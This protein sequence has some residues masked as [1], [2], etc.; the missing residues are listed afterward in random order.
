VRTETIL[1]PAEIE[2]IRRGQEDPSVISDYFF[3]P[4]GEEHG[5]LFDENFTEKGAWQKIVHKA[6]QRDIT[7]IGGFG[8]GKT[9]GIGMSAAVWGL[10]IRDFKFLNAAPKAWQ[11]KLMYDTILLNARNTRFEDFIWEKPRKPYPK[12]V[13]RFKMEDEIYESTLEFMSADKDATGILSWEG[14]WLHIDEAGLLD[15]LEEVI[16]NAGTRLRGSVRRRDRLGRFSMASNSWDNF[17]LWYYFD[18]AVADPDNFLSITVSSR[19]NKN[20]T[21]KQLERM[22]ARIPVRE[23]ER[24][25]EGARPEGKGRYFSRDHIYECEDVY[26]GQ[27][28]SSL[29]GQ[30]KPGYLYEKLHGAG[31]V[32]FRLPSQKDHLY[33]LFG[34]PGTG[35]APQRNAP[36]LMVWDVN[37]FPMLPAKLVAFWWGSGNG[38]IGPWVDM[39]FTLIDIYAPVYCG[40]DSTGP[41]KNMNYLINEHLFRERYGKKIKLEETSTEEENNDVGYL[42][43]LGKIKGIGALDFSGAMKSVY[44]Q[45]ARLLIENKLLA[46]PRDI[47]GIRSQLSNYDPENDKKIAQDI[48]AT[49]GMTAHG[50]RTWFHLSPQELLAT[51]SAVDKQPHSSVRRL[52]EKARNRRKHKPN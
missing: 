2:I 8:S 16:I 24:F 52:P 25:I 19:S 20:I 39:M 6:D 34:D 33:M 12:L 42:S 11:A 44:L 5:W 47:V 9:Q 45:A 40:V 4:P 29:A 15:N 32:D 3:R 49:I 28:V 35:E 41:Q 37:A 13:I 23:R 51:I 14:D 38:R 43:P 31:V 17:Y 30:K 18:Q 46:W 7:I 10:S 27:I 48:V 50:I 26:V 22:V 21:E 36:V 1:T